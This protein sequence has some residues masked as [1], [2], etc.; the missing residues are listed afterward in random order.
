MHL[1][2]KHLNLNKFNIPAH[3]T[4]DLSTSVSKEQLVEDLIDEITEYS[5]NSVDDPNYHPE[6]ESSE[7]N[8]ETEKGVPENVNDETVFNRKKKRVRR[9]KNSHLLRSPCA[10][11]KRCVERINE[12]RREAIWTKF[13]DMDYNSRRAWIHGRIG[14]RDKARLTTKVEV[15]NRSRT[16]L[17]TLPDKNA[18]AQSVCK[19]L[20]LKTLGYDEKND[21]FITTMLRNSTP[22]SITPNKDRRGS[23]APVNKCNRDI[24]IQHISSF[25]PCISHYRREHAPN[26][27]YL[28]NDITIRSMFADYL[29]K[30]PEKKVSY[31]TY[32]KVVSDMNISFT[33]LGNEECDNCVLHVQ[34]IKSHNETTKTNGSVE[35]AE[36]SNEDQT[37]HRTQNIIDVTR[38]EVNLSS[39]EASSTK[40]Q[41]FCTSCLKWLQH[42]EK[43]KRGRNEYKNDVAREKV[44]TEVVRSVDL[45]KVIMLPRIPGSQK[46]FFT[47]RIVAFHLTFA[48]MADKKSRHVKKNI[49]VLWHEGVAGRKAEEIA[50]AYCRALVEERDSEKVLYWTDN[51]S[52]QNKNWCLFTMFVTMVN[53]NMITASEITIKYFETGHT[54]M[55]ADSVHHGVE[56]SMKITNGGNIYDFNDFI[57]TVENSNGKKMNVICLKNEDVLNWKSGDSKAKSKKLNRPLLCDISVVQFKRGSRLLFYKNNFNDESFQSSFIS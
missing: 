11:K 24:L 32:R 43:A 3:V 26:R 10:C 45:Q 42:F 28:P 19:K 35:A 37:T 55:S 38:F 49:S 51:C 6:A 22:E 36:G 44:E 25:H 14:Q 9:D 17:Y 50:S 46:T 40:F 47:R 57:K 34:H 12:E 21:K 30:Y 20:F 56:Q 33:K 41:A 18:H 16:L 53:T 15:R 48:S 7:E 54:F 4:F 8:Y 52:A 13:Y 29:H 31:Y 1:K 27:L 5:D 2:E 23:A 39:L